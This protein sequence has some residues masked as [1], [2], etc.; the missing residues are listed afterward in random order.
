[1]SLGATYVVF[2]PPVS[3]VESLASELG[4]ASSFGD[5]MSESMLS[6]CHQ[7]CSHQRG[8]GLLSPSVGVC[9]VLEDLGLSF[10][11]ARERRAVC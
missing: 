1:M 10:E 8:I 2:L 9:A 3:V 11:V 7:Q 4:F 5:S 6:S